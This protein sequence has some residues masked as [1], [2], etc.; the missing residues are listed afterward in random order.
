MEDDRVGAQQSV[1]MSSEFPPDINQRFFGALQVTPPEPTGERMYE[2]LEADEKVLLVI[3]R[4]WTKLSMPLFG[5][6]LLALLPV[7]VISA[8]V[9]TGLATGLGGYIFILSWFWYAFCIYYFY[10]LFLRWTTNI[11][12]VTNERIIDLDANT[13]SSK[14][15]RDYDLTTVVNVTNTH[16][17]GLIMGGINRGQVAVRVFG[18]VE[19]V[20]PEVPMPNDVALAIGELVEQAKAVNPQAAMV[21]P[22]AN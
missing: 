15:A 13:I 21:E 5:G 6:F 14:H 11:W 18:G 4:H 17:G 2:N 8:L 16:G 12:L 9:A 19:I 22:D 1:T 10:S 3:R 20:M 7:V